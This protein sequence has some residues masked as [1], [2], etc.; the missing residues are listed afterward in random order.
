MESP[1]FWEVALS[2]LLVV[3][4]ELRLNG[5]LILVNTNQDTCAYAKDD[6]AVY[7]VG[8]IPSY[9]LLR[10][11]GD[12]V[13]QMISMVITS[14][15]NAVLD[16]ILIMAIGFHGEAIVTVFSQFLSLILVIFYCKK[17]VYFSLKVDLFRKAFLIPVAKLSIPNIIQ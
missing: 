11:Y 10:C 4:L 17:K 5:I 14:F 12:S 15:L 8:M 3:I 2:I 16:P 1:H 6:L 9:I 7:L 13:F